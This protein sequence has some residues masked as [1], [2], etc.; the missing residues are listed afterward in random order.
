M[1]LQRL[2]EKNKRY[3]RTLVHA[4]AWVYN[5]VKNISNLERVNYIIFY[6]QLKSMKFFTELCTF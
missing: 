5:V 3:L 6:I 4:L 2:R 1:L